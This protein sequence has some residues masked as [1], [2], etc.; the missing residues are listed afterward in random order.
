MP[1]QSLPEGAKKIYNAAEAAAKK[2]TCK[3]SGER[4]DECAARVAWAAVKKKYRKQ[5]DTWVR[6]ESD[7]LAQ[8]SMAIVK[9]PFDNETGEMKWRSV[10][11]DTDEDSYNDEMTMEL[12]SDFMERI[13]SKYKPPEKFCSTF[14]SGGVPYLSISHYPDLDGEGVPG[15]VDEIFIDGNKL[16]SYGTFYD[17]VLGKA[18][19]KAIRKDLYSEE[20]SEA[21]DKVRVSIAFLDW[22]HEHKSNGFVFDREANP[23]EMCPE[24]FEELVKS[25]LDGEQPQGKKFLRGQ[26]IHLAMTRVPVNTRTL[27]EVDKSMADEIKTRLDDAASIV[28]EDEANRLEE[29]AA[30]TL[31]SESLVIKSETEE[32]GKH[33]KKKMED[34]EEDME[35]EKKKKEKSEVASDG[36]PASEGVPGGEENEKQLSEVIAELKSILKPVPHPLDEA[37]AE[38]KATYDEALSVNFSADEALQLIQEPYTRL[39]ELVRETVSN[40][41]SGEPETGAESKEILRAL[42]AI[43]DRMEK[44]EQSNSM[45]QAQLSGGNRSVVQNAI[46]QRRSF[47]PPVQTAPPEYMADQRKKKSQTPNL[48]SIVD[49]SV[50]ITQ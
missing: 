45:L 21:D 4:Q 9:A 10:N 38:L 18:C 15:S 47:Q 46:P 14:W 30:E 8:F 29:L 27:M 3:D 7:A 20:R 13:K 31:Q 12:F 28:G 5:G 23:E 48:R 22:K 34:E 49:R 32:K 41:P 17:N 35:D 6:K 39:G 19:W 33:D 26:L 36:I 25:L 37:L 44:L 42:S 43:A 40:K 1:P 50:G 2:S 24:C 11:S 16:K